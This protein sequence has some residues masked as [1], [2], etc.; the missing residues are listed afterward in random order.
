MMMMELTINNGQPDD[1][2]IKLFDELTGIH[3]GKKEDTQNWLTY[4]IKQGVE[5]L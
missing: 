4:V 2:A 5:V 1:L 3:Y